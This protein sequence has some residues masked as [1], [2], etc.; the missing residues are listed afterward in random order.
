MRC[1]RAIH[2]LLSSN[3]VM[4]CAAF[5][6]NRLQHTLSNPNWHLMNLNGCSTS[7]RTLALSCSALS[8]SFPH[9][10]IL[11]SARHLP[12]CSAT[13]HP[14][15]V[16]S[17]RLKLPRGGNQRLVLDGLRP[18]FKD[19]ATGKPGA[20]PIARCIE[21]EAAVVAG[22][23]RLTCQTDRRATRTREA[24]TGLISRGVMGLNKG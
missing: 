12:G 9:G 17:V 14:T 15:P 11:S 4:R 13:F 18:M 16:A 19:G 10:Q 6:A 24:I 23:G 7:A 22:A 5:L 20:L 21:L 3:S 2:E 1:R 8:S